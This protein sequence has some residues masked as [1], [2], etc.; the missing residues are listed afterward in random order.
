MTL[1]VGLCELVVPLALILRTSI[2]NRYF[3]FHITNPKHVCSFHDS[4]S[5]KEV[6]IK[7][8]KYFNLSLNLLQFDVAYICMLL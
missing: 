4:S 2:K 5:I 7:N 1:L 6:M 8:T 3:K